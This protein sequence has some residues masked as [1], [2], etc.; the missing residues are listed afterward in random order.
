MALHAHLHF[1]SRDCD[2][3]YEHDRKAE[4]TAEE[5]ESAFGDLEFKRR[6]AEEIM[7]I[8]AEKGKL[9]VEK[10]MVTWTEETEEGYRYAEAIWCGEEP[11]GRNC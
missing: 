4:M 2:G 5:R 10:D 8:V 11:M 7:S 6:M 3:E 9:E 1:E